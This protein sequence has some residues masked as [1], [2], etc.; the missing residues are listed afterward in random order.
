MWLEARRQAVG[1][2]HRQHHR[3]RDRLIVGKLDQLALAAGLQ[4]QA[5]GRRQR[6]LQALARQ[7]ALGR[8]VVAQR[9]HELV[10]AEAAI[11]WIWSVD[12]RSDPGIEL[13]HQP[14]DRAA[15]RP[16][17]VRTAIAGRHLDRHHGEASL[18]FGRQRRRGNRIRTVDGAN[19][20][21]GGERQ[22]QRP[23]HGAIRRKFVL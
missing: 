8:P 17:A 9:D 6:R 22:H 14:S 11:M 21:A 13:V 20:R 23:G 1:G 15:R 18:R 19:A 12:V 10:R 2:D 3:S 4:K 7:L 16:L 5:L